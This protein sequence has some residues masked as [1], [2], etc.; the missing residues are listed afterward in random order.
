M[1]A[2]QA[3]FWFCFAVIVFTYLGYPLLLAMI[4]GFRSKRSVAQGHDCPKLSVLIAA[5]NE[6]DH[7]CQKVQN[8]LENGYPSDRIEVIVCSDG[9]TDRTNEL[10]SQY[11][12]QR[13]RLAASSSNIGVNEVFALGAEKGSG[14]LFLMTD[15]G[16]MFE[17]GAI[18]K[19]A[20]LF[21]DPQMGLATGRIL[22]RNP[23]KS[24]V[25]SGYSAYWSIETKV[26]ELEAKLGFAVVIV[27][28]FEVIRRDAYLPVP[29]QYNNDMIA[30]MHVRAMGYR[31]DFVSDA[32]LVTDQRKSP[33]QEFS[34]RL[35]MAIRGWSSIP[36]ILKAAPFF[37]NIGAW[38][39][40]I[41][42]KYLRWSTWA[43]MIGAF[44]AS[45][46]LWQRPL[47]RAVFMLQLVF[48][49]MATAG[50]LL[51][52]KNIRVRPL[53]LPFY[54]CLLQAAGMVGLIETLRGKRL[55]VWKPVNP[56]N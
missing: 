34:R 35:R 47:F 49:A 37:R 2:V 48:Y 29:S 54:F 26:R 56:V 22:Y 32:L 10:V 7:I 50:W 46:L 16:A 17:D 21:A 52:R 33:G 36:Y 41:S 39:T 3:I 38:L 27:G 44:T 11:A 15:T 14:D 19:V 18:L 8:V 53:S 23:L 13:V 1:I 30:P 6:Q 20:R 24:S 12:D 4:V 45:G 25:G 51:A 9:S 40:L 43:F 5:H 28:A 55:A 31:A 42:H